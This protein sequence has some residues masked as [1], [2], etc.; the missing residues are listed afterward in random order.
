MDFF[1]DFRLRD[2][3]QKQQNQLRQTSRTCVW[4]F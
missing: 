2:T 4:N 1:V 3:F